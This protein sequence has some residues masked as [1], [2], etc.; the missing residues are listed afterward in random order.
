MLRG[1]PGRRVM[2]PT[3]S[4]TSNFRVP[5][6]G[7]QS[8]AFKSGQPNYNEGSGFWLGQEDGVTK[9]S[10]G[11]ASGNNLTWDGTSLDINGSLTVTDLTIDTGDIF[12]SGGGTDRADIRAT[13]SDGSDTF[14]I[15]MSAGGGVGAGRGGRL[16]LT[17]NER[18]GGEDGQATLYSGESGGATSE[19]ALRSASGQWIRIKD[20][21]GEAEVFADNIVLNS[22]AEI[23]FIG[24]PTG[25]IASGTYSPTT[26]N[27]TNV[28]SSS[29]SDAQYMR[30][31]DVVTVS[32]SVSI[33][34][35]AAGG[36]ATEMRMTLP[37]STNSFNNSNEAG[38][39]ACTATNDVAAI[40]AEAATQRVAFVF[41]SGHT[42]ARTYRYSFTY[43]IV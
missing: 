31:G 18:G 43:Q 37:I 39:T 13:T 23:E 1:E 16:V 26:S 9:L 15:S 22:G 33:D 28:D 3:G 12:L 8:G 11:D 20:V 19:V 24:D 10:I 5:L 2:Q 41:N 35:T 25:T 14:Q 32:G 42:A 17:G 30:V 36:T 4:P 6:A 34:P 29:A 21:D 27:T 40:R 38:G 7:D